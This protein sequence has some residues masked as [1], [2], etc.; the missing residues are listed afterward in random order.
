MSQRGRRGRFV[1][2]APRQLRATSPDRPL[3]KILHRDIFSPEPAAP[4]PVRG[5]SECRAV[6]RASIISPEIERASR[7]ARVDADV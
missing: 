4:R 2:G 6:G 5:R 7:E 3:T 1:Y